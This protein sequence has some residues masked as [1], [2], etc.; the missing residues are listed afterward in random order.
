M[1]MHVPTLSPGR[2]AASTGARGRW[3]HSTLSHNGFTLGYG[4]LWCDRRWMNLS[5]GECHLHQSPYLGARRL[6]MTNSADGPARRG[7]SAGAHGVN[8]H[9][10]SQLLDGGLPWLR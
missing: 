4:V 2:C 5:N 10:P 7:G 1:Y 9:R 8:A 6:P 3:G